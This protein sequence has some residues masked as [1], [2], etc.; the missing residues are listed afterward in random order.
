MRIRFQIKKLR[1]KARVMDVFPVA[2]SNH[3]G[4]R[5]RAA[6]VILGKNRSVRIIR[7]RRKLAK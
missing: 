5:A 6:I 7:R 3:E 2:P 4:T 1:Y